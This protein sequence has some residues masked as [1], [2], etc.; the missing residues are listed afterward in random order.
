MSKNVIII[1]TYNEIGN[2]DITLKKIE[3]LSEKF[4]VIIVDDNSPDGTA[5]FVE[6]AINSKLYTLKIHL[7]KRHG[8]NGLG[9]AYIAG[10]KK[11]LKLDYDFIFQ[12][13]CDGSHDPNQLIELISELKS[14]N[15]DIVVGSR[16]IKGITVINWPLSRLLLSIFANYYVKIITGLN[17]NDS[18]GGFNGYNSKALKSIL[19]NNIYFKGYAFQIQLK[20]IG[21]KLG[22]KLKELPIIFKDREIGESKMSIKIT[23]EAFFGIIYM[24]LISLFKKY[25]N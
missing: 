21:S 12:L 20:F 6:K 4:D 22:F 2:I 5:E 25:K 3:S 16:Y 23:G 15:C 7:I 14:N 1:P 24:K 11:S 13:D 10:F 9:T 18:T 19:N 17:I 8:K